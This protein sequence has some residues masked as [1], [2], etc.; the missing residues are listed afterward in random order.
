MLFQDRLLAH[1]TRLLT[2]PLAGSGRGVE[3]S[4]LLALEVAASIHLQAGQALSDPRRCGRFA[5]AVRGARSGRFRL[6][7]MATRRLLHRQ[8]E[9]A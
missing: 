8:P 7:G 3:V 4:L 1:A 9:Q 2:Y 5:E 6:S